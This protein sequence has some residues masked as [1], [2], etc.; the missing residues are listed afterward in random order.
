MFIKQKLFIFKFHKNFPV[1][2]MQ[3]YGLDWAGPG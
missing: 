3:V 1:D 2:G